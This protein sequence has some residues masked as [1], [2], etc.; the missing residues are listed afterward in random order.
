VTVHPNPATKGGS[1]YSRSGSGSI[2]VASSAN[3]THSPVART[4][5]GNCELRGGTAQLCGER[6][7]QHENCNPHQLFEDLPTP[8]QR[9]IPVG[10]RAERV[11]YRTVA[12]PWGV[13]RFNPPRLPHLRL[14]SLVRF[15]NIDEK[16]LVW[17]KISP[18]ITAETKG[19][20]LDWAR[21]NVPLDI[22]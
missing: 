11:D 1:R 15:N 2:S 12:K 21:F 7:Y 8:C 19:T 18:Y 3:C 10:L 9:K 5:V 22:F 14:E 6:I 17:M 13:C 16:I 20:C 4:V